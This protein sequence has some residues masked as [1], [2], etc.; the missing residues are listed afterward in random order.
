MKEYLKKRNGVILSIL[1]VGVFIIGLTFSSGG[2]STLSFI[3]N[4]QYR[5]SVF[6]EGTLV[7]KKT[8]TKRAESFFGKPSYTTEVVEPSHYEGRI[9]VP[10]KYIVTLSVILVLL[11]TG[12][13]FLAD[14]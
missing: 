10:F 9:A 13:I 3:Q 2:Y 11:G 6:I 8:E 1:G 5:E 12:F 4:I 14:E 7:P